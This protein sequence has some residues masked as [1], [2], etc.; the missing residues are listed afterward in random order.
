MVLSEICAGDF[1]AGC[2][3]WPF[4]LAVRVE[5]D[6]RVCEEET[7]GFWEPSQGRCETEVSIGIVVVV[8]LVVVEVVMKVVKTISSPG[9]CSRSG[10]NKPR[11]EQK[12]NKRAKVE[13][14][15]TE[16]ERRGQVCRARER[17]RDRGRA[18][19]REE[20]VMGR[21]RIGAGEEKMKIRRALTTG[22]TAFVSGAVA[23]YQIRVVGVRRE[24]NSCE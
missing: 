3:G 23:Q 21:R 14:K 11:P 1:S 2:T 22:N 12:R 15:R 10:E 8:V 5:M 24:P 16:C 7:W 9:R 13:S 20:V 19:T 18:H 6:G 4:M 17:E